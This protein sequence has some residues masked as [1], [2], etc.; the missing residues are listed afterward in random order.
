[1]DLA[2]LFTLDGLVT[3]ITLSFLEIILGI[4]NL[5]FL[6]IISAKLPRN[7]QAKARRI[8]LAIALL[9]RTILLITIKWITTLINPIFSIW[10][11]PFSWRDLILIAGGVFLLYKAGSEIY[12]KLTEWKHKHETK[13]EQT[14]PTSFSSALLQI[15]VLD[16]VFSLDSILT[17]VGLANQIPIMIAAIVV[18]MIV[19]LIFVDKVSHFIQKYPTMKM[20]AL[21]FLGLVGGVLI[22]EGVHIEVPKGYIYFSLFF[23]LGVELLNLQMRR[24]GHTPHKS[25]EKEAPPKN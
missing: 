16:V 25:L 17:A 1:M 6:S 3:F 12:E 4:D 2:S 8:G 7:Q 13:I 10:G 11:H 19:M 18:A 15:I 14:A 5:L 23:C 22:L 9:L 20:L 21:A 24:H